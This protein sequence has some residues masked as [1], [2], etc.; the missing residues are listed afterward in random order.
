MTTTRFCGNTGCPV[1]AHFVYAQATRCTLC[2]WDL[3]PV[4]L[5]SELSER[6]P[7]AI[8]VRTEA[9]QI[10]ASPRRL[11]RSAQLARLVSDAPNGSRAARRRESYKAV[12]GS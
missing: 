4:R 5:K 6:E 8:P 2:G 3:M 12:L 9:L 7:A 11:Q 10:S 1:Y